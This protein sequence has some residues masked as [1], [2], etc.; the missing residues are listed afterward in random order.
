[1]KPCFCKNRMQKNLY[2]S[3]IFECAL[4]KNYI[5]TIFQKIKIIKIIH[6]QA[7]FGTF[8]HGQATVSPQ[9]SNIA[10][11]KTAAGSYGRIICRH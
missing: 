7:S 10:S 1:M 4:Q 5:V 6:L 11:P 3:G 9:V 2:D 8:H